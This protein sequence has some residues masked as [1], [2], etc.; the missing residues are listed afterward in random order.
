MLFFSL[1]FKDSSHEHSDAGRTKTAEQ[2]RSRKKHVCIHLLFSVPDEIKRL[3]YLLCEHRISLVSLK[4]TFRAIVTYGGWNWRFPSRR[5]SQDYGLRQQIWWRL[6]KASFMFDSVR[7]DGAQT[8]TWIISATVESRFKSSLSRLESGLTDEQNHKQLIDRLL[9][10][11]CSWPGGGAGM[12]RP[13]EQKR[14]KRE[15]KLTVR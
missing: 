13:L 3:W 12:T 8:E 5:H 15:E 4:N 2:R 14:G 11:A 10:L 1:D 9:N 6:K 7:V